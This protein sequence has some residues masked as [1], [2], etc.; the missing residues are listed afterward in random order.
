VNLAFAEVSRMLKNK[1]FKKIY[2]EKS[3]KKEKEDLLLSHDGDISLYKV[4]KNIL[5]DLDELLQEFYKWKKTNC[6]DETLFVKFLKNKFGEKSVEFVKIVGVV[7]GKINQRT[8]EIEDDIEEEY[9][10]TKYYNF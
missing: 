4:D 3:V 5:N 6:Y 1:R 2:S 8:G 9:K 10:E 7:G